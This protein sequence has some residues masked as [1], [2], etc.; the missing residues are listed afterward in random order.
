MRFVSDYGPAPLAERYGGHSH[1]TVVYSGG[2]L[3]I[4]FRAVT[5][6]CCGNDGEVILWVFSCGAVAC[7]LSSSCVGPVVCPPCWTRWIVAVQGE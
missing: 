5:V 6:P 4:P 7:D 1:L 3:T 2:H